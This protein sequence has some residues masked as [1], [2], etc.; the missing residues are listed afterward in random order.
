MKGYDIIMDGTT[1]T[2]NGK[3]T[4]CIAEAGCH[5][6]NLNGFGE[7]DPYHDQFVENGKTCLPGDSGFNTA[8]GHA[9]GK[10]IRI[11]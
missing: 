6:I 3:S 2:L 4:T 1:I 8:N 5:G 9:R 7:E 10:S 11:S